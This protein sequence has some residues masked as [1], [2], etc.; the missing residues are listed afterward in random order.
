MGFKEF[1]ML[2]AIRWIKI[3]KEEKYR[4]AE[5]NFDQRIHFQD[6]QSKGLS[7]SDKRKERRGEREDGV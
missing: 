7:F 1:V 4:Q 6:S 3:T 2:R 5:E